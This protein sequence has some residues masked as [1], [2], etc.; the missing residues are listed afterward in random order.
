M[1]PPRPRQR[2]AGTSPLSRPPLTPDVEPLHIGGSQTPALPDSRTTEPTESQTPE[3]TDSGT[4]AVTDQQS[5]AVPDSQT[6]GTA[7]SQTPRYLTLVRKEA[8]VR[9][10]QAEALAQLRRRINR[11][12][13]ERGEP[14]TDNTLIRVAIDLLTMR[15]DRLAGNTED[16]LRKSVL[17]E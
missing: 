13:T 3:A 4:P 12:R 10:D 1:T 6:P 16:E 14:I 7:E 2:P 15:A 8:R 17:W 5:P 9:E 11:E